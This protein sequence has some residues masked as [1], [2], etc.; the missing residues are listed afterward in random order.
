MNFGEG[1]PGNVGQKVDKMIEVEMER[2]EQIR[3]KAE[4]ND[5]RILGL[6]K[7]LERDAMEG[8]LSTIELQDS[9]K[10]IRSQYEKTVRLWEQLGSDETWKGVALKAIDAGLRDSSR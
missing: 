6:M 2:R 4:A 1:L 8:V 3:Q 5:K 7:D 9:L 10:E